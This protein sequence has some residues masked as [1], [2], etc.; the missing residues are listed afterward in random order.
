MGR[1]LSDISINYISNNKIPDLAA[2][3]SQ[4]TYD[5]NSLQGDFSLN[6]P[7]LTTFKNYYLLCPWHGGHRRLES[8]RP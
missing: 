8:S 2:D 6:G 4:N 1:R 5:I 7:L 3:I